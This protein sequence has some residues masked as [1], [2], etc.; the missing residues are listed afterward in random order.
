ML[1]RQQEIDKY[2]IADWQKKKV[3]IYNLDYDE[4]GE[5]QYYLW[6]TITEQN[7]DDLKIVHF[8]SLNITFDK[9]FAEIDMKY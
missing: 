9:L 5:P 6:E 4:N 8:L 3:E 2:W 1:Y 7:K